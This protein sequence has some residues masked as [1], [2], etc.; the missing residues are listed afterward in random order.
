MIEIRQDT[1]NRINSSVN[2]EIYNIFLEQEQTIERYERCVSIADYLNIVNTDKIEKEI[3]DDIF[4][5]VLLNM[6]G[7][8]IANRNRLAASG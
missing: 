6:G 2:A 7:D 4:S 1:L 3:I 8:Y 5:D